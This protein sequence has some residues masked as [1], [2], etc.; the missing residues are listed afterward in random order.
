MQEPQKL[1]NLK[2]PMNAIIGD[3]GYIYMGLCRK[4]GMNVR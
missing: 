1:S 4:P 3:T 2:E